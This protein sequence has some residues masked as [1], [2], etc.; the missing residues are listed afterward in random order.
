MET[1]DDIRAE[2]FQQLSSASSYSD[3]LVYADGWHVW[4]QLSEFISAAAVPPAPADPG[5][6]ERMAEQG[7][8][9]D[10]AEQGFM[11][12]DEDAAAGDPNH[13][14]NLA[15]EALRDGVQ[16]R[17]AGAVVGPGSLWSSL[18]GAHDD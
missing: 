13:L 18:P 16:V 8:E 12:S 7:W 14:A 5:Q 10:S 3:L 15:V 6:R 4:F 2:T 11:Y 9:W 17:P 1:W